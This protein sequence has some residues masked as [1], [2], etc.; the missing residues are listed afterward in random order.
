MP[1][2][3]NPAPSRDFFI[4]FNKADRDWAG[5]I[6]WTL[7]QHGY[8]VYFQDWD[9][10]TGSES[11]LQFGMHFDPQGRSDKGPISN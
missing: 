6:A 4:S 9:F 10:A 11:A 2:A 5:W 1:N 3:Q 7:E 8:S